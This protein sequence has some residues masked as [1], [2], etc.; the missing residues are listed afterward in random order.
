MKREFCVFC[1]AKP[2]TRSREHVAPRWLIRLTGD[3]KRKVTFGSCYIEKT[4]KLERR[5]FSFDE[6]A[7]PACGPCNLR[8][9]NLESATMQVMIDLLAKRSVKSSDF[10][11]LLSWLDKVRVGLWLIAYVTQKN[12]SG[13]APQFYVSSRMDMFD[14]M[15]LIYKSNYKGSRLR[16]GGVTTPAFQY[17]PTCFSLIVNDLVF[18]NISTDFLLSKS[19]GFPYPARLSYTD[20]PQME[21]ELR[22]GLERITYPLIKMKYDRN[23]SE[24]YQPM[25]KG[26]IGDWRRSYYDS[27][28]I[29]SWCADYPNGIGK[30]LYCYGPSVTEYPKLESPAWT[31]SVTWDD[32]EL[33]KV[34]QKQLLEFQIHLL[35]YG[36]MERKIDPG[37]TCKAKRRLVETQIRTAKQINRAF[38]SRLT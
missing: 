2:A 14:R 20:T 36:P 27:A 29:R 9:S 32:S 28:Y 35:E 8:S 21:V 5:S 31:P 16:F 3:P 1:G 15:I 22:R 23:C 12:L 4:K 26:A 24:I 18:L 7:F 19:M 11:T 13:I 30:L 37:N 17:S 25:I 38:L 34:I 6:F 10:R 33:L